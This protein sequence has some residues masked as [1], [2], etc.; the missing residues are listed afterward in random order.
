M[1]VMKL[2]LLT[3]LIP[4]LALGAL[5][6]TSSSSSYEPGA[7]AVGTTINTEF[8]NIVDW[9]NGANVGKANLNALTVTT[10]ATVIQTATTTAETTATGSATITTYGRP[11]M[12]G[13]RSDPGLA[14]ALRLSGNSATTMRAT[15]LIYRNTTVI[16]SFSIGV[17]R[18]SAESGFTIDYPPA[19]FHTLDLQAPAGSN[20]YFF[21]IL[22]SGTDV[23]ISFIGKIHLYAFEL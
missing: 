6:R 1:D 20:T 19:A 3:L 18:N 2:F 5:V 15:V 17:T 21:K 23:T 13:L 4:S 8:N 7:R 22:T 10:T 11:V 9:I 14:S 12:V 16:N